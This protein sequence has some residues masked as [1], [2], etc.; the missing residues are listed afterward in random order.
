MG[1]LIGGLVEGLIVGIKGAIDRAKLGDAFIE[2]GEG[3]KRG[4]YV[5]D[6]AVEKAN[7]TL[8]RMRDARSRFKDG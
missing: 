3:I 8:E 4:K 7:K 2:Y 1:E 5:S 6:E